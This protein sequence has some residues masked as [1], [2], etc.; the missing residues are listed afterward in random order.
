MGA[1]VGLSALCL[2][3]A[4]CAGGD[5]DRISEPTSTLTAVATASYVFP[6]PPAVGA[7]PTPE[8]TALFG[9]IV[10]DLSV[11][12]FTTTRLDELVAAG[13][14]RHAWLLSDL[15]RFSADPGEL[16]RLVAAFVELTGVDPAAD[17]AFARSPWK[18]VTDHLIAWD[19]PAPPDYREMKAA[20][21]TLVEPRWAPFFADVDTTIDW[22]W[23]SWGGVLIDDRPLGATEPCTGGCI[24]ALDDPTLTDAVRGGWYPDAAIVF[25]IVEGADVI[26]LPKHIMEVHEMVNMTVGGRRFGIPY[27][28]LCG[29]AQAYLTDEVPDGVDVPVLRTSGLLSRSNKMMYDLTTMSIFDT[30]TGAAV[31]G[32]LQDAGVV[33]EQGTVTVTTWGEW[34]AAHP[35]TRIVAEDAGIGRSYDLDPLRGRD[36]EGPIFPTGDIDP[37]L[38]PHEAVVGVISS[39]G[40]P[41]A[42]PAAAARDALAAGDE[43]DAAG[44]EVFDDGGGL[45]ARSTGGVEVAAHEAF[46]FAWSQFHPDTELWLPD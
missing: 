19:L 46:W 1:R 25:G 30:F 31:S 12:G 4:G 21:F 15:L 13:D 37:R 2:I 28:T 42:F 41:V 23:V 45:R 5:D 39:D 7:D 9:R 22:R 27:C 32:P 43:V 17:P 16:D 8:A 44:V 11:G 33:L 24:P 10:E 29:S 38:P 3:A 6:D 18:S 20:A 34:K 35:D 26:A 14:A 36:D 40:S